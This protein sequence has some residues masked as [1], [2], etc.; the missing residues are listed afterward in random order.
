MGAEPPG[1]PSAPGRTGALDP[2]LD[3]CLGNE[4]ISWTRIAG[5]VNTLNTPLPPGASLN[6][7]PFNVPGAIQGQSLT[8]TVSALDSVGNPVPNLPVS[9]QVFGA[10]T[11]TLNGTTLLNGLAT[12]TYTGLF[13]GADTVQAS[14]FISGLREISNQGSVIWSAPG[15]AGSA[16]APSI[17]NPTPEDGSV[18]TKPVAVTAT[19]TPPAAAPTITSW[20]VFYQA[21]DPG[22][23]VVINSGTGTPPPT[24]ATF[25]PTVLPNDTYA[26]TVEATAS[27]GAVQAVTTTVAVMGY[28]KPGRYVTTYQDI[29]VPVGGFQ[30]EVRRTYDSID[31]SNGDF[32]VGWKVSVANFRTAPNRIL[33]AGGWT[34]Y[35]KSCVF[36]LCFTGFKNSAPR[37]VM[38]TF[39]DQH[40]EFFDFNPQGGTNLFWECTPQFTARGSMGTTSTLKALDDTT[41]SYNGDGNI[42]GANGPYSPK[43]FQLTT[44]DGRVLVLDTTTGL[45]SETDTTG[46]SLSVSAAGVRSTLGP[47]SSPTPGPSITFTR[48][49]QG[50]ITD[51]DGPVSGQH[52]HY[53]YFPSGPNELQTYTDAAGHISSYSY[54][55]AT[56]NLALSNDSNNQPIE[57]LRYDSSGRLISIA[58]GTAPPTVINTSP[59]LQQQVFLDPSGNLTT[60]LTLDDTGDVIQEDQ[61]FGGQ[62]ALRT[63][64]TYDVAG[65]L[66]SVTDP[67][68]HTTSAT[69]DETNT[70]ANGEL[71]TTTDAAGRTYTYQNYTSFGQPGT[72][73]KPDGSVRVT[74]AYD[75]T[76][77]ALTSSQQPGQ[78]PTAYQYYPD[79]LLQS[80]TEPGGRSEQYTYDANGH[81]R[82]AADSQGMSV[83]FQVDAGG[84]VT[85]LTDQLGNP[86]LYQYNGDGTL[87]KMT[88]GDLNNWQFFYDLRGRM[89]QIKDSF[90]QSTFYAFNSVGQLS[91]RTDRNGAVTTFTYD[92]DGNLTQ[93]ARPNN[94]VVNFTYDPLSR[95]VEADNSSSHI[96]RTYDGASRLTSESSCANTGSPQTLCS[97]VPG[98]S[99]PS[100]TMAYSW[101]PDGL[102]QSVASSDAGAIQYTYDGLGRLNSITDAAHGVTGYGYDN[103]GRVTS[104]TRPNG[105]ND[106][107]GYNAS[108]DLISRDSYLNGVLLARSDYA[109]DPFS[110]RRVSSTNMAGTTTYTYYNNGTLQ[111]ATHPAGSGIPNESYT[112]DAAGNRTSANGQ[113]ATFSGDRLQSDGQFNYRYDASGQL[114]AKT[115]VG[116][117]AGTTYSWDAEG[118]LTSITYPNSSTSNYRYDPFGRRIAS[119]DPGG[120]TRYVWNSFSVHA[121][122]SS[123]NQLLASYVPGATFGAPLEQSSGAQTLYYLADGQNNPSALTNS[124][125]QVVGTYSFN[126]FGVPQPG[127]ASSNRYS[128]GGYQLDSA[129]GLY[130]AGA[131]YYDPATGRFLSEDPQAAVNPYPY[132]ANDPI[133]LI[134]PLG[135]QAFGE[136][137]ALIKRVA[138]EAV[139]F[140]V[141]VGCGL[142]NLL[143]LIGLIQFAIEGLS[144]NALGALGEDW[145]G[146]A[147]G[148]LGRTGVRV[149]T[150]GGTHIPDRTI[151]PPGLGDI[152]LDAKNA[153]KID[154]RSVAQLTDL[155]AEGPVVVLTRTSLRELPQALRALAA[156]GLLKWVKCFPA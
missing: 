22:P 20:R 6:L 119:V 12:F 146:K 34:Q 11:Q 156:R 46:N 56:G 60:V 113:P 115:P 99:Q 55:G 94:D 108:S 150:P 137:V 26:I 70:S 102:L 91:Q 134:D 148:G 76:T 141:R 151:R 45:I 37:F 90:G 8:L 101:L 123:Q 124:S 30:M 117:G 66:T 107:L 5:Q 114:A 24:L 79:G 138:L 84:N 53:S 44:K 77:G 31:K 32:G 27:N 33:G 65:R 16:L 93:V 38:V 4:S 71:L 135:Q 109:I 17:T 97:A 130:Y 133:D 52:L 106:L 122:Y 73:L 75:A 111:S 87:A 64:F 88:D 61:T 59:N 129:S 9:L 10:N 14:A 68:G 1:R 51:I 139:T 13:T 58:N 57:T 104:I 98:S 42:Y 112:Y 145:L 152:F 48:D 128:Y 100:V 28:L 155:S 149:P 95:L 47:A 39:P 74:Y 92:V 2:D 143:A 132:A 127:N 126:S 86:T 105:V 118:Q 85:S 136:Y 120:E 15:G 35:N 153:A 144:S 29:S 96:D 18:I 147:T 63:L 72:V 67:I 78:N 103:L 49:S 142:L 7:T 110:G 140:L 131:R 62:P 81:L 36:G 154:A 41:C 43:R 19:I 40:T 23:L 121:D 25:D 50:R 21:L 89:N 3:P 83:T 80:I 54:E 69:Y 82:T 125:G 116:G